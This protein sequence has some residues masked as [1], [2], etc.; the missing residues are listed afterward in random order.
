MSL[1]SI[2][3][4]DSVAL[5]SSVSNDDRPANCL[6]CNAAITQPFGSDKKTYRKYC[7]SRCRTLAYN[8]RVVDS[9]VAAAL[10]A[11]AARIQELEKRLASCNCG[12]SQHGR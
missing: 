9:S 1:G 8:R 7:N 6:Y 3:T 12:A 10:K 4:V 2:A 11:A 5:Y